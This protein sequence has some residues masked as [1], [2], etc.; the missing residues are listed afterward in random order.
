MVSSNLPAP[1]LSVFSGEPADGGGNVWKGLAVECSGRGCRS[2]RAFVKE[3]AT[4]TGAASGA[5]VLSLRGGDMSLWNVVGMNVLLLLVVE[6]MERGR[7][8][9]VRRVGPFP[10]PHLRMAS[11]ALAGG[12]LG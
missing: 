8:L 1:H 4:A 7:W 3:E 10:S 6:G 11:A 9:V 5:A 2:S 12:C